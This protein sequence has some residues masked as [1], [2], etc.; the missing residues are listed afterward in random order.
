MTKLLTRMKNPGT[1][2]DTLS[3]YKISSLS[4][5]KPI[6]VKS[7]LH[8]RRRRVY[9]RSWNRRR[10]KKLFT[11]TLHWN[12]TT[13]EKLSWNHRTFTPQKSETNGIAER[14]AR[15]VKERT[16]AV[17]LLSEL[18]EEWSSNSMQYY[19]Y[20]KTNPYEERFGESIIPFDAQV[21]YLTHS[22]KDKARIHQFGKKV[23]PGIYIGYAFIA[24]KIWKGDILI[25]DFEKWE[26]LDVS[27][28]SPRS[29]NAKEVLISQKNGEFI[30][31]ET[32][33]SA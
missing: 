9:E 31:P 10:S 1:I 4:G 12:L 11:S 14:A 15:R 24:V 5:Q 33:D 21:E 17:L 32:D 28:I 20:L 27:E 23:L 19:C 26:K 6:R 3:W 13:F 30:F 8:R 2:T 18:D 7:K 22:E 16:S 29:L 25:A